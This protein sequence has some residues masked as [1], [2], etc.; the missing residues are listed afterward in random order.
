MNT[1]KLAAILSLALFLSMP[2]FADEGHDHGPHVGSVGSVKFP[3]SCSPAAQET[4]SHAVALLHSFWYEE[5]TKSFTAAAEKDPSCA[6]AWWGVGMSYYHQLWE[7]PTAEALQK[8]GAALEKAKALD[9]KTA[10]ERGYIAAL[11]A[12]YGA[13]PRL[14]Y[15]SRNRAYSQVMETVYHNNP[16]DSEAA[17]FY[18]LSLLSTASPTDKTYSNQRQAGA[19][20]EKI[21]AAQPNHPGVAHYIIHSYDNPVLASQGLNAARS[22]AQIAPSVPHALH[23][24]SHIFVRLGLWDE[25]IQSNL[26]AMQ[27]GKKYEQDSAMGAAWDQRL[28]PTDYLVYSYLQRGRDAEAKAVV[29]EL[30]QIQK[31]QPDNL[32]GGYV[33][34]AVPARYAMERHNWAEAAA[35]TARPS[36]FAFTE[37][38]TYWARAMGAARTGNL[39]AAK[40]NLDQLRS[41]KD[42]LKAAKNVYWASQA[43]VLVRESSAWLTH[44]QAKPGDDEGQTVA[45]LR[46]AADL[47]DSMDKN[48]ITP[49]PVIPAREL[50]ADFLL[51]MGHPADAATEYAAE[52]RTAPNRFNS[53]AGAAKAAEVAGDHAHAREY[54]AQ[55]VQICAQ[56][57]TPRPELAAA[58]TY[59]A[60]R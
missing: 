47:E 18:A 55:L 58:R 2:V 45:M 27:A 54:Y 4:F 23:M 42:A 56:A 46:S 12:F 53:L 39:A 37:A 6:M 7:P 50:L 11:S 19:I 60:Q 24:P 16:D 1:R 49:G 33:L 41:R 28:H 3:V 22:Y 31:V 44:A 36:S 17:I 26:A 15:S 34:A 51:E 32:T 57:D 35:L 5:A 14:D 29:A 21:F 20:L 48:N 13:D 40:E 43:E 10:R 52:L 38:I 8:G 25:G 30:A 59:L 9:A